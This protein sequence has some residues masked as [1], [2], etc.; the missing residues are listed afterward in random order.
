MNYC[1]FEK[2]PVENLRKDIKIKKQKIKERILR[3]STSS[4][5]KLDTI[6]LALLDI[7]S[8]LRAIEI[9]LK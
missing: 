2:S 4:D 1:Q 7:Q 8:R 5:K 3:N 6:I 9:S